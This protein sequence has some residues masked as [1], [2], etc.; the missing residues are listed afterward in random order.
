LLRMQRMADREYVSKDELARTHG[1]IH[2]LAH[3]VELF[4]P[5]PDTDFKGKSLVWPAVI[6]TVLAGIAFVAAVHAITNTTGGIYLALVVVMLLR[7]AIFLSKF[8]IWLAAAVFSLP[9]PEA[10]RGVQFVNCVKRLLRNPHVAYQGAFEAFVFV[11]S[12]FLVVDLSSSGTSS[13]QILDTTLGVIAFDFTL[14]NLIATAG[15]SK[16]IPDYKTDDE[17]FPDRVFKGGIAFLEVFAMLTVVMVC[18]AVPFGLSARAYQMSA[19]ASYSAAIP[20]A[21]MANVQSVGVMSGIFVLSL[22]LTALSQEVMLKSV[23]EA[24]SD[25]KT[26]ATHYNTHGRLHTLLTLTVSLVVAGVGMLIY[27]VVDGGQK[28]AMAVHGGDPLAASMGAFLGVGLA[29][30]CVLGV[31]RLLKVYVNGDDA[32]IE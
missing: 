31:M 6:Q 14:V 5:A 10:D 29:V 28:R 24:K 2:S 23:H 12:V 22:S 3:F 4:E 7:G 9:H 19:D 30:G 17:L 32:K 20:Q 18:V 27:N 8:A 13:T 16:R 11:T 1:F 15:V 25:A 26:D 21:Q